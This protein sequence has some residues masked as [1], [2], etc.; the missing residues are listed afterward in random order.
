MESTRA[1][2]EMTPLPK[3]IEVYVEVGAKR[4]FAGAIDW[5]GWCRNGRDQQSA[6]QALLDYGPRYEHALRLAR[7]QF[8]PP[9]DISAFKLVERLKGDITTDFGTPGKPP[10]RDAHPMD[11]KDLARSQRIL[12]AC[13]QT[14]DAVVGRAKGKVLRK[15]PRGGGRHLAKIVEH[16]REAEVA[17][18][19]RLG[20]WRFATAAAGSRQR[21]LEQVRRAALDGLK[22]AA[23]GEIP[24]H[25]PRGGKHWSPRY[26]VRRA[27][28]HVLD[29]AW[30]IEDRMR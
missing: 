3:S 22:A 7:L 18:V 9:T 23:A 1:P 21:S 24:A 4:V 17:Y 29:H 11:D 28:W 27:A 8:S 30:E 16:V 13:W 6:L 14:F 20:W 25:G 10:A 2:N 19:E 15:G 26:F 5:P 12:D